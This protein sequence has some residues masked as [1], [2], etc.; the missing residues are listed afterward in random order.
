MLVYLVYLNLTSLN[1][2]NLRVKMPNVSKRTISDFS[3]S[4]KHPIGVRRRYSPQQAT[5][6]CYTSSPARL[7]VISHVPL[8]TVPN[9][10]FPSDYQPG[11]SQATAGCASCASEGKSKQLRLFE[12]WYP[13]TNQSLEFGERRRYRALRCSDSRMSTNVAALAALLGI[14]TFSR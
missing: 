8:L 10:V 13:T 14:F 7:V 9:L 1:A 3:P 6:N 4:L 5:S 2:T 11:S 12:M